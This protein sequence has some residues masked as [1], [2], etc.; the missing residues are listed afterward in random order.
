MKTW[1]STRGPLV[2]CFT[3][4]SDF[5]SYHSGIYRHVTGGVEGGHC[6]SVVGYNDTDRC[7]ICK[8]SWDTGWGES[9]FF[10]IEYG[11]SG[12]DATMWAVDGVAGGVWLNNKTITGLW[13]IDQDRNAWA[14]VA[15]VGWRK[16]AADN[17]NIFFNLLAQLVAAKAAR[18]PVNIFVGQNMIKQ[19]YVL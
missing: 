5:Y 17:D 6:I 10:R 16:I 12:I 19:V 3:V 14:Y 9:G 2:A 1:L 13:A 7:W 4:Y 8:N 11:D 15:D 18:R